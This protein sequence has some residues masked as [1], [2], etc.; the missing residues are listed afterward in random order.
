M[1]HKMYW[2]KWK[3]GSRTGRSVVGFECRDHVVYVRVRHCGTTYYS[4]IPIHLFLS[5]Y[6]KVA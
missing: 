6:E 3:H 2:L 5:L 4:L 1:I